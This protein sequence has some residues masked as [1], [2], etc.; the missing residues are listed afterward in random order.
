MTPAL[1]LGS[2][3]MGWGYLTGPIYSGVQH[4]VDDKISN[5]VVLL[6]DTMTRISISA[7]DICQLLTRLS[8]LLFVALPSNVVGLERGGRPCHQE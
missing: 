5:L 1:D 4:H 3:L 6:I 7:P 8:S 2:L